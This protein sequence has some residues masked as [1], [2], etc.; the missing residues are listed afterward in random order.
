[1]IMTICAGSF[2]TNGISSYIIMMEFGVWPITTIGV[3][4]NASDILVPSAVVT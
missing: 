2:C 1:M 3:T 4:S